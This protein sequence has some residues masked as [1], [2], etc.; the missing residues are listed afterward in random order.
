MAIHKQRDHPGQ[1]G[2]RRKITGSIEAPRISSRRSRR[3]EA[4]HLASRE[5]VISTTCVVIATV[6]FFRRVL[7]HCRKARAVGSPIGCSSTFTSSRDETHYV[8][9]VVHHSHV[10]GLREEGQGKPGEPC[11]RFSLQD[12]IGRV[13]IP[14]EDVVEVRG[15]KKVSL[16]AC[17]IR[18]MCWWK[19]IWTKTPG[20]SCATRPGHGFRRL[21]HRAA[22]AFRSGS[23]AIINRVHTPQDRP[24]AE[25][26]LRTQ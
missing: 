4:G 10:L 20:T 15:G 6:A 23:D 2:T 21:G 26:G 5:D 1:P 25:G 24:K 11:G 19:W 16:R 17:P 22:A 3:G 9:A 13:L 12:K 7:F 18:A 14:T 8:D